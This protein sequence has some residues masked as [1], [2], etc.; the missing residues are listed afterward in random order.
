MVGY[1]AA[2]KAASR[3]VNSVVYLVAMWAAQMADTLAVPTVDRSAEYWAGLRVVSKENLRAET[4]VA[5]T[6]ERWAE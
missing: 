1:W 4:K 6:A 3:V 2:S 5:P